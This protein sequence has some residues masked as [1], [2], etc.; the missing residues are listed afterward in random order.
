MG[1]EYTIFLLTTRKGMRES[2][3]T[4]TRPREQI[5]SPQLSRGSYEIKHAYRPGRRPVCLFRHA[6]PG[7]GEHS[8]AATRRRPDGDEST[9]SASECGIAEAGRRTGDDWAANERAGNACTVS[10][11]TW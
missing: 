4:L 3:P 1:S 11:R 6:N 2:K 5:L 9:A 10:G 8:R 7:S